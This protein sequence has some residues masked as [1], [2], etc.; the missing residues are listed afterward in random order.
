MV[1]VFSAKEARASAYDDWIAGYPGIVDP[2]PRGD[3]DDDGIP[4]GI[5]FVLGTRPDSPDARTVLPE[6]ALVRITTPGVV[7]PGD[8]LKVTW[9]R[10]DRANELDPSVEISTNLMDWRAAAGGTEGIVIRE[11]AEG[12]GP[13]LDRVEVYIPMALAVNGRLLA[14]LKLP[15]TQA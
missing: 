13:F 3:A 4:N 9:R 5:E 8:Y 11:F 7:P 14:R 2:S 1:M 12:Y 15:S 10:A 6:M